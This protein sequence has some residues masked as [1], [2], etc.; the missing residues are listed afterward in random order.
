MV[1]LETVSVAASACMPVNVVKSSKNVQHKN[2]C[3]NLVKFFI[4][5]NW[6]ITVY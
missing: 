5:I 6:F 2:K 4:I 1:D 3:V